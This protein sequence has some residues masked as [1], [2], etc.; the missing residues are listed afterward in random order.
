MTLYSILYETMQRGRKYE[1][2]RKVKGA[3]TEHWQYV[4]AASAPAAI[5]TLQK[6]GAIPADRIVTYIEATI[7][8]SEIICQ[9]V[10]IT[11]VDNLLK[12]LPS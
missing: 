9:E 7:I 11:V 4:L 12:I 3:L 6:S 10:P 1:E 5:S 2:E 8:R